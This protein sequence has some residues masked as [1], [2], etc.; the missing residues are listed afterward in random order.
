M[1]NIFTQTLPTFDLGNGF[2]I[3]AINPEVDAEDYFFYM[4]QPQVKPFISTG[5]LPSA[6]SKAKEDLQYWSSLFNLGKGFYWA[7]RSVENQKLVG[8]LGFNHLSFIHSKGEISYDLSANYWGKGIMTKALN[9]VVDF[10]FNQ[11]GL[12]R[13]QAH[14]AKTNK[15]SIKLLERCKFKLEGLLRKFEALGNEHVDCVL[16]AVVK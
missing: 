9:K 2:I 7:I 10:G 15:K 5:N 16:Y 6:I 1:K 14:T 4:N 3:D 8:T 13:I 11:I 12:V